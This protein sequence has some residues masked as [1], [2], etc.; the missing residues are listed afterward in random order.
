MLLNTHRL[1]IEQTNLPT[2]FYVFLQLENAIM[3]MAHNVTRLK[4]VGYEFD[5]NASPFRVKGTLP[6]NP[7]FT[8]TLEIETTNFDDGYKF[9]A[10]QLT[11]IDQH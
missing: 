2:K 7:H 1:T 8:V 6:T 4:S 9:Y 5:V 10:E 11:A 3:R